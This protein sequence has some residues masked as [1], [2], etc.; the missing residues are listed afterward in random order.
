P[1]GIPG[2]PPHLSAMPT[3][4]AFHPRCGKAFAPCAAE[5]PP[6]APP[7]GEPGREVACHL[8]V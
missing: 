7:T 8:H 4:C 3:G 2:S 1:V 5:V 6:L